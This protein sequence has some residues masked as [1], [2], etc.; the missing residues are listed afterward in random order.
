MDV[1]AFVIGLSKI[2]SLFSLFFL[3][4]YHIEKQSSAGEVHI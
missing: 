2:S 4:F 1:G 3:Q